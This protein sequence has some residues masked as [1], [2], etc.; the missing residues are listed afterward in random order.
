[1][2]ETPVA[3]PIDV[4][5]A[6]ARRRAIAPPP[7][8]R[9]RPVWIAGLVA[10]LAAL[11][12]VAF[13]VAGRDDPA[14]P[15]TPANNVAVLVDPEQRRVGPEIPLPPNYE[16]TFEAPQV[17][18]GEGGV[19]IMNGECVCQ[20]DPQTLEVARP[21]VSLPAQ[22]ALGHRAVWVATLNAV[23]VPVNAAAVEASAPIELSEGQVFHASITTTEDAVWTAFNNQL[24]RI[25]PTHETISDPIPLEHGADDVVGVGPDMWVVDQLAGTLYLYGPN[26]EQIDSIE[27]QFTPDDVVA[28]PDRT[29]WVLNRSGGTVTKI[30][31]EGSLEQPIRVGADATDVA[32]GPD[33]VWVADR[34]GHTIQ[35]IDPVLGQKDK[36]IRLPGPVAAIGVDQATGEVWAYLD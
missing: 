10:V 35:R 32:V 16:V 22:M 9:R 27:L 13:V 12:V 4:H 34:D 30:D 17:A 7:A 21:E 28:G 29:L 31:S 26:G 25:D 11:G 5:E 8:Y 3:P 19:W 1:V 6:A 24:A 36:P 15:D 14:P 33:A 18:V 23:I 20:I 2:D